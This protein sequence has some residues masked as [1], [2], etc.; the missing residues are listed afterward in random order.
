MRRQTSQHF[1][2][3][4]RTDP[5]LNTTLRQELIHLLAP[6][7]NFLLIGSNSNPEGFRDPAS[8]LDV[9]NVTNVMSGDVEL[10]GKVHAAAQTRIVVE[11]RLDADDGLHSMFAEFI[12]KEAAHYLDPGLSSSTNE[13]STGANEKSPKWMVFCAHSHLEWHY[14]SPFSDNITVEDDSFGY[15]VGLALP[16]CITPGLSF[17]YGIGAVRSNL[18]KANHDKLN[19]IIP[20]CEGKKKHNANFKNCLLRL[21]H[22]APTAIRARTVRYVTSMF[23]CH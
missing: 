17:G 20:P 2:W 16:Y 8:V 10:A 7:P 5:E 23:L 15:L 19:R 11:S 22:L 9:M 18:P 13:V 6:H 3:I 1:L 21:K 14:S 12:Q 4:I